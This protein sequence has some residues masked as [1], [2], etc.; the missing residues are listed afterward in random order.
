MVGRDLPARG[1]LHNGLDVA[2]GYTITQETGRFCPT[3]GMSYRFARFGLAEGKL[4]WHEH[5]FVPQSDRKTQLGSQDSNLD[6]T[7]PKA[8][9]TSIGPLPIATKGAP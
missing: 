8:G 6:L 3:T 9:V 5:M 2:A 4:T 7:A 1:V